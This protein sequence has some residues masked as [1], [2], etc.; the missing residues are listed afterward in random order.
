[1]AIE[2]NPFLIFY[3]P[4]PPPIKKLFFILLGYVEVSFEP[5]PELNN[6]I[7]TKPSSIA[8]WI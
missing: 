2:N 8:L 1:M 3:T 5:S 6:K 7:I 4:S